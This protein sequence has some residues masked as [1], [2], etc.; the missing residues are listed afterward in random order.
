MKYQNMDVVFSSC[1]TN[2]ARG[3]FSFSFS[4]RRANLLMSYKIE[5]DKFAEILKHVGAWFLEVDT[6]TM[7]PLV[8]SLRRN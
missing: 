4:F 1:L 8:Q 2:E 5:S 3:N 7:L 6:L